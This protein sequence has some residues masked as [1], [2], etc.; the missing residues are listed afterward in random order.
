VAGD[1]AQD[2]MAGDD[3][4]SWKSILTK[5]MLGELTPKMAEAITSCP[6]PKILLPLAQE[7]VVLVGVVSEP[8][9]HLVQLAVNEKIKEVLTDV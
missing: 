4:D 2:D 8:L 5:A 7:K 6:A 3:D 9:P 1:H